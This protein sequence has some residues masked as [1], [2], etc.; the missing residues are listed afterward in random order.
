MTQF[1]TPKDSSFPTVEQIGG[2]GLSLFF[3]VSKG[4][5]VPPMAVLAAEFFHPWMEEIKATAEWK[6]FIQAKDDGI[7]AAATAVKNS[8]Q[9][10]AFKEEQQKTIA[11]VRNYL[12]TEGITLMAVR[13]SSPRPPSVSSMVMT[14]SPSLSPIGSWYQ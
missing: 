10:L 8:C 6:T 14:L 13:S 7:A 2:K 3:L 4:F 9:S 1:F 5:N 12:Q 11:E